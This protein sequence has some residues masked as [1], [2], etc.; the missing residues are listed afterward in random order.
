SRRRGTLGRRRAS[1]ADEERRTRTITVGL[2][3][4]AREPRVGDVMTGPDGG[5]V[6]KVTVAGPGEDGESIATV[7]LEEVPD[8]EG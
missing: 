3:P 1:M 6:V 8:G 2:H 4:G 5:R 7:V